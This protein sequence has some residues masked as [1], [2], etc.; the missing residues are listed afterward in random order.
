MATPSERADLDVT[1]RP[2]LNYNEM[3]KALK[4]AD[5][6]IRKEMD[7]TI[8]G[9]INPIAQV[10]KGYIHESPLSGWSKR[11]NSTSKWGSRLAW[12]STAV[13]RGIAVRQGKRR[14]KNVPATAS[15]T[16]WGIYNRSP[17]GMIY[18][19]AGKRSSGSTPAGRTFVQVLTE[20][21]HRPSRLIW[22]AFTEHGGG[23]AITRD[24]A[25]TIEKYESQLGHRLS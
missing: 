17:A 20:R 7:K 8:R 11:D 15:V 12:D 4:D 21:G 23:A 19:L 16:A 18:E 2:L 22:R 9:F 10:A 1:M 6:E 24:V 25:R 3:K 14:P 13:K 5:P